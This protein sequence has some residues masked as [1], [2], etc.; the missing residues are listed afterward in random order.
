LS[1]EEQ[2]GFKTVLEA[3]VL[4]KRYTVQLEAMDSQQLHSSSRN[5]NS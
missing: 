4:N 3:I 1:D 5:P 2:T